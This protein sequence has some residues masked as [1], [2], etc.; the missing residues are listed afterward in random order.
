[1]FQLPNPMQSERP[2]IRSII[3]KR[4]QKR[5]CVFLPAR[6]EC[7]RDCEDVFV[8]DV[9][10]NGALLEAAVTPPIGATVRLSCGETSVEGRVVWRD[11]TWFGIEFS[12]QLKRGYL[13]EQ[14]SARLRVSAPRAHRRETVQDIDAY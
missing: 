12:K 4:A 7:E 5:S 9:S 1:M 6:L 13:L 8:R 3:Q 14:T 10:E 11:S 2:M